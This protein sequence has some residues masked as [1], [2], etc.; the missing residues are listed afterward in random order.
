[1]KTAKTTLV[2]DFKVGQIDKRIYGSFI[3]HLGRA[4]Y[5][6]IYDPAH[7]LADT[8]GFRTDVI[9]A[10]KKLNVPIVRY[11]GGNFVSGY[12]WEDGV[13]PVK[14]RPKRLELAWHVTETNEFGTN[15]F[16][17]WCKKANTECMMAVNLGLRGADDARNLL[18]YCNHPSGSYYSDLRISHGVKEP[19]NIKL[20]CLGN[21]M[22]GAWQL[23]HKSAEEYGS[24]AGQT[25][26]AMKSYD[27]SIETVMCGS[28]NG[29][30]K[31]FGDWEATTLDLAYD[32]VDYVSLHQ[33]YDNKAD[34]SDSFLAK[35]MAMDDFINTVISVCDYV[36]GKKH[37]T[38]TVNLSF[39]EWNV[40]YHSHGDYVEPWSKA[41]HQLEDIYNFE[42]ALLVGL[43]LISLLRRCDR[44]KVACLAQ[45]VNVIAPIMTEDGGR[46]FEQT[47]FYPFEHVSNFGRGSVLRQEIDCPKHDTREFTDV[48]D[49][50]GVSVLS[51]D[52]NEL[53]L[54]V[55]N[56]NKKESIIYNVKMYE[57][58]DMKP[59]EFIQLEGFDLKASNGFDAS[60]VKPSK[61]ELPKTDGNTAQIMLPP[62]SWNVIRFKK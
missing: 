25:A 22:D 31:T 35:N 49:I 18:E 57:F 10:V 44:V 29:N 41:P 6:G 50:D 28:S 21:E 46:M 16:M 26:R 2:K 54:F 8:D 61:A 9:D 39:D 30:M 14:D 24:L 33:Y 38:H 37:S 19:Y 60:K 48:P 45:L 36:K 52:E 27:S 56:R 55:V 17:R 13:G 62:L 23:G 20:W 47:I 59:I 42:D 5:G 53:T 15:E 51:D 58:G 43:M 12:R 7:P 3:E 4:V 34:D 11:P 40:W 32:A 1:M